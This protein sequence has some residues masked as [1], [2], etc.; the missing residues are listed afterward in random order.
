MGHHHSG[1]RDPGGVWMPG[2]LSKTLRT[3]PLPTLADVVAGLLPRVPAD[4]GLSGREVS[5]AMPVPVIH[6]CHLGVCQGLYL[7]I[8]GRVQDCA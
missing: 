8:Q 2:A 6:C 3:H 4:V 5:K 1:P 7:G